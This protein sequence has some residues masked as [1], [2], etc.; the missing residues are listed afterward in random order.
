MRGVLWDLSHATLKHCYYRH[1]MQLLVVYGVRLCSF[2]GST[3]ITY[4]RTKTR[5]KKRIK[6]ELRIIKVYNVTHLYLN[7]IFHCIFILT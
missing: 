2:L 3:P 7:H 4:T 6:D 5:I 1:H